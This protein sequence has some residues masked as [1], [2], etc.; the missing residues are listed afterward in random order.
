M[1]NPWG[2]KS[3]KEGLTVTKKTG[4]FLQMESSAGFQ[5][6]SFALSFFELRAVRK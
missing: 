1:S 4:L 2:N 3:E 5:P 6:R